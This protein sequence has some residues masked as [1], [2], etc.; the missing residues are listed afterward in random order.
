MSSSSEEE[1]ATETAFVNATPDETLSVDDTKSA[2]RME[3]GFP[4]H[5]NDTASTQ[6][7][8]SL[9]DDPSL[10]N[11][12]S[13]TLKEKMKRGLSKCSQESQNVKEKMKTSLSKY[14]QGFH[15]TLNDVPSAQC[16][17]NESFRDDVSLPDQE[18]QTLKEKMKRNLSKY[19]QESQNAKEK[20]KTSLSKYSPVVQHYKG[21]MDM[22][23][24]KYGLKSRKRR[25]L[26]AIL[27]IVILIIIIAV[28]ASGGKHNS[29]GTTG[30]SVKAIDFDN[31]EV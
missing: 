19:S 8:D 2:L 28:S 11:Q 15:I 16:I 27:L 14:S 20:M 21:K 25:I 5:L 26:L 24:V 18:S 10:P 31:S 6:S 9:G 4:I 3:Q 1:L 17:S 7:N 12:D 13:Q 29:D 22:G 30:V 23:L